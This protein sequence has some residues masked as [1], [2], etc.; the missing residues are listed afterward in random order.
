MAAGPEPTKAAI[1]E[2]CGLTE[3][4]LLGAVTAAGLDP[5]DVGGGVFSGMLVVGGAAAY[6]INLGDSR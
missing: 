1:R 3:E 4:A 2:A 5:A 6:A